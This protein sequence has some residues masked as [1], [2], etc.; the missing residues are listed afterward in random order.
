MPNLT[1]SDE[2]ELNLY[3]ILLAVRLYAEENDE[4]RRLLPIVKF[5]NNINPSSAVDK[6]SEARINYQEALFNYKY[7]HL[8]GVEHNFFTGAV[9][10]GVIL[11]RGFASIAA[12]PFKLLGYYMEKASN[13]DD[14]TTWKNFIGKGISAVGR[15]L[16][17]PWN[18]LRDIRTDIN[19]PIETCVAKLSGENLE[20]VKNLNNKLL[21][22]ISI[23]K[24]TSLTLDAT[25][26]Y[27]R[28]F[29]ETTAKLELV[30]ELLTARGVKIPGAKL[31]G[32]DSRAP[33]ARTKKRVRF[34]D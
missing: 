13:K 4:Y 17:A 32:D 24:N 9:A 27:M 3:N 6:M 7:T 10:L 23:E 20:T 16:Q 28:K 30:E 12:A 19:L 2:K 26:D 25:K 1:E 8:F 21:S 29:E 33:D 11:V 22:K 31:G 34:Q 15:A 14:V 5:S 18:K